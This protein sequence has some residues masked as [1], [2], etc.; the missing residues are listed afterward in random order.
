MRYIRPNSLAWWAGFLSIVLG[1]LLVWFPGDPQLA[2]AAIIWG[3]VVNV[4][5]IVGVGFIQFG[6]GL[7][8]IRDKLERTLGA[9]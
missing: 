6:A 5:D 2:K 3:A 7:V 1:A 9:G 4:Q 8:G